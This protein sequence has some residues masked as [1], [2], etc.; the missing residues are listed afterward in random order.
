[1]PEEFERSHVAGEETLETNAERSALRL[2]SEWIAK[3]E[4][5][6]DFGRYSGVSDSEKDALFEEY[7]KIC[8]E[9]IPA[10]RY[11]HFKTGPSGEPH[12]YQIYGAGQHTEKNEVL[13]AYYPEY[14]DKKGRLM[15]LPAY[16]FLEEVDRD[17]YKGPRFTRV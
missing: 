16:M 12:T 2:Y 14:G 11:R 15:F 6:E 7:L 5:H 9:K 13:V 8:R 3:G 1:M 10:G 4:S 17:G